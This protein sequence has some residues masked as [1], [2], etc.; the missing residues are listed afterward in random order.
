V[1]EFTFLSRFWA[2]VNLGVG[3]VE[4]PIHAFLGRPRPRF[5]SPL[6]TAVARRNFVATLVRRSARSSNR[7]AHRNISA[8]FNSCPTASAFIFVTSA[9]LITTLLCC[10]ARPYHYP[11]AL[12]VLG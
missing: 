1:Y 8:A 9:L 3:R 2:A 6:S 12:F 5:F 11:A 7:F 4:A 10:G